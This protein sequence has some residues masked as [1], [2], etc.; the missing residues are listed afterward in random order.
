MESGGFLCG[1]RAG[2]PRAASYAL[3]VSHRAITGDDEPKPDG[4]RLTGPGQH[5]DRSLGV[6]CAAH[7]NQPHTHVERAKHLVARDLA[8][9]L[10]QAEE[11]WNRPRAQIDLR[12]AS[13]GKRPRQVFGHAAAGDVRQALDHASVEQRPNLG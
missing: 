5:I 7:D 9:F 1:A 4:V 2:H 10:Q 8:A 12:R 6:A 11:R 13:L 3:H